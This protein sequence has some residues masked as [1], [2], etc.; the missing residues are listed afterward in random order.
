LREGQIL[1]LIIE[2]EL[3]QFT[4]DILNAKITEASGSKI[5]EYNKNILHIHSN[6]RL[7][8]CNKSRNPNLSN[9]L[10]IDYPI[11]NFEIT[12]NIMKT[13][14]LQKLITL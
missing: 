12:K 13:I 11:L 8:M 9:K 6:F 7:L 2:D 3:D 14:L 4:N 10:Y 5:I 1:I